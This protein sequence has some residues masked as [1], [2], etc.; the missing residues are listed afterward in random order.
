MTKA[1]HVMAQMYCFIRFCGGFFIRICFIRFCGEMSW[2]KPFFQKWDLQQ[3][4]FFSCLEACRCEFCGRS[5]Q[6]KAALLAGIYFGVRYRF[7]N[8]GFIFIRGE[9]LTGEQWET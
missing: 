8:A 1:N 4:V 5:L 2:R 9:K 3:L 6:D 7:G